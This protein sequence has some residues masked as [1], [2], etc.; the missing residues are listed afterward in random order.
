MGT[1]STGAWIV[2]GILGTSELALIGARRL[3]LH[4]ADL[5]ELDERGHGVIKAVSVRL[6]DTGFPGFGGRRPPNTNGG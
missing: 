3:R 4:A 5:V 2:N 6:G 1:L